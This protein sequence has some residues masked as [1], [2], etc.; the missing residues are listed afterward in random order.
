MKVFKKIL[1]VI[2][3]VLLVII[4]LVAGLFGYLTITEYNPADEETVE[5]KGSATLH[6][7]IGDTVRIVA[8]N[9]G[10]GALG[11]NADF[12]MDGGTSVYTADRERVE[13]NV[14][15]MITE[16]KNFEPDI[17]FLQ[18]AD[19]DSWRSRSIN[20][21][22]LFKDVISN[23]SYSFA[24][25][26]KCD[27][28]PIPVPPMGRVQSG[29]MTVSKYAAE[30]AVRIK[31]PCPFSWPLKVANLK[32]CLLV[33][34]VKIDGSDKELV[35][36]N[37]HL[38]AYDD[39][40]GKVEQTKM[41]KN[42][43]QAEFDKGNYVI[44]GGDFNQTFSTADSSKFPYQE[45]M[46]ACGAIDASE[47][48]EGWQFMMD[49]DTPSCR[50]LDKAYAGADHTNFQYYLIDGFIVSSNITVKSFKCVDFDFVCSDHNPVVMEFELN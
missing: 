19:V 40:E 25:N 28:V 33:E 1:K 6:P 22:E 34:R 49:E 5:V 26:Y 11:D 3:I 37:L 48:G 4:L 14:Q 9:T 21:T 42:I 8:W 15:G 30:S 35:L 10:Y 16:L 18:E 17:I 46:W 29:I 2:L 12:F 41:L 45:G 32:R 20:E 24:Y 31:L 27:F 47:F 50:S 43:M 38:E 13:K 36:I 44:A 39:G 7:S 23:S